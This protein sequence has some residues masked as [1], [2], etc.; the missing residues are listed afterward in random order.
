V[1]VETV[2]GWTAIGAAAAIAGMIWPFRRGATGVVVNL[3]TGITGALLAA[4][5][6]YLVVPPTPVRDA[7]ARLLV[8]WMHRLMRRRESG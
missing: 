7:P 5:A 8:V 6:S 3:L 1:N 2:L 4:F